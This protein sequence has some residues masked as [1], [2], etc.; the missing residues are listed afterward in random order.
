MLLVAESDRKVV[1]FATSSV[2]RE[3]AAYAH[4]VETSV[5]CD[6][7]S[8]GRGVGSALYRD[9]LDALSR[10]DVHR[11]FAGIAL[12]NDASRALHLRCGFEEVG[13]YHEVGRKHVRWVDVRWYERALP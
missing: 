8:L 4:S 7:E 9:L 10:E 5:Y 12:P 2:F 3:R 11:A 6:R 1:G 13:T